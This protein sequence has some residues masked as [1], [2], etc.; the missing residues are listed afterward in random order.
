MILSK[1]IVLTSSD[2]PIVNNGTQTDPVRTSVMISYYCGT[3]TPLLGRPPDY[4]AVDL[5]FTLETQ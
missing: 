3:V 2:V 4:Y 1:P 5:I